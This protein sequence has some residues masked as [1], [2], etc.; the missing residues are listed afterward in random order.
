MRSTGLKRCRRTTRV[1]PMQCTIDCG[2]FD[3]LCCLGRKMPGERSALDMPGRLQRFWSPIRFFST[4]GAAIF[5]PTGLCLR[6]LRASLLPHGYNC[7][8]SHLS[9]S[10]W[11]WPAVT[12]VPNDIVKAAFEVEWLSRVA[13]DNVG[14]YALFPCLPGPPVDTE[15][16]VPVG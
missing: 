11:I 4:S 16:M 14:M 10:R 13:R 1:I 15:A 9:E 8:A 5:A 6:H 7:T 2:C 12:H 3:S